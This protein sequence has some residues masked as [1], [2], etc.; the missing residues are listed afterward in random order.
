MT[1]FRIL[2]VA[3]AMSLSML[4]AESNEK[5]GSFGLVINDNFIKFSYIITYLGNSYKEGH[6]AFQI[7]FDDNKGFD[8]ASEIDE[9]ET[10]LK[11]NKKDLRGTIERKS[12]SSAVLFFPTENEDDYKGTVKLYSD[13]MGYKLQK[14][15][16]L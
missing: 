1:K 13:I 16:R 15:F 7:D 2:I 3:L 6:I 12:A 4:H 10:K 5:K 9:A 11:V 8:L 14:S